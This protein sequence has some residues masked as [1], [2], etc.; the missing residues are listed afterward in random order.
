MTGLFSLRGAG[1]FIDINKYEESAVDYILEHYSAYRHFTDERAY[2]DYMAELDTNLIQM[3]S[4]SPVTTNSEKLLDDWLTVYNWAIIK[5]EL[6]NLSAR[7]NSGDSVLKLLAAPSRLEFL[8][9]LAIRSKMPD[10]RVVPNY[11][12]DDT[13]LPTSTAGGNKGDIECYEKQKGICPICGKKFQIEDM[14]GDHI[15]PWSQGGKTTPDN[16]QL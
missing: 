7:R 15:V 9:A 12:C 16:L 11:C 6:S 13:G 8:T 10:V 14:D 1:R 3:S 4:K 2:F 5:N